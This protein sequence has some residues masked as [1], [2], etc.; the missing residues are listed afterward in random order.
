MI[1]GGHFQKPKKA[2][3]LFEA[4]NP[5]S[6]SWFTELVHAD[7]THEQMQT[8][9]SANKVLVSVSFWGHEQV[10]AQCPV[11]HLH[12]TLPAQPPL[13]PAPPLRG[14]KT[15]YNSYRWTCQE[16]WITR[17]SSLCQGKMGTYP[18]PARWRHG[19]EKRLKLKKKNVKI[20][21]EAFVVKYLMDIYSLVFFFYVWHGWNK[22]TQSNNEWQKEL[23]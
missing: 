21:L 5:E 22:D 10:E 12:H 15:S 9:S 17:N 1:G 23:F 11:T 18:R 14:K 19:G 6:W 13:P 20:K 7:M 4:I 3:R 16:F 8:A 2:T